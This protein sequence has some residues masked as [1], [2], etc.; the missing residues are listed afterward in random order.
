MVPDIWILAGRN[1]LGKILA[2]STDLGYVVDFL[3][4]EVENSGGRHYPGDFILTL[5]RDCI[6]TTKYSLI[7]E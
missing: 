2:A 3:L 6:E 1:D 4:N 5:V 7:K